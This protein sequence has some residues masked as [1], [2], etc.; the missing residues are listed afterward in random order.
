MDLGIYYR[1]E[2]IT[3]RV[4]THRFE[5]GQ[6]YAA[7]VVLIYGNSDTDFA[8]GTEVEMTPVADETGIYEYEFAAEA[9]TNGKYWGVIKSV[10]DLVDVQLPITWRVEDKGN[11]L[12]GIF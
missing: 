4:C 3:I 1:E 12:F 5:S 11:W 6:K 9:L 7:E 10:I 8:D 2:K